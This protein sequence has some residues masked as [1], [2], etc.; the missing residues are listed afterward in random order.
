ME[1]VFQNLVTNMANFAQNVNIQTT[2]TNER[3]V[4]LSQQLAQ[5]SANLQQL[6]QSVKR[7]VAQDVARRHALGLEPPT[8]NEKGGFREWKRKLELCYEAKMLTDEEKLV[9]TLNLL[10]RSITSGQPSPPS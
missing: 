3:I 7:F 8:I 4:Q 6:T 10:L 9:L 1:D 5:Q 2:A